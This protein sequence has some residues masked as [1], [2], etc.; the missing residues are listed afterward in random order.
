MNMLKTTQPDIG[1][2]T[3]RGKPL[4]GRSEGRAASFG[5]EDAELHR[6]ALD[7]VQLASNLAG[8]R[9]PTP[10]SGAI[11][12]LK[13]L[14]RGRWYNALMSGEMKFPYIADVAKS[15]ALNKSVQSVLRAIQLCQSSE[16]LTQILVPGLQRLKNALGLL[17]ANANRQIDQINELIR[18]YLMSRGAAKVTAKLPDIS[19]HYKFFRSSKLDRDYHEGNGW[20]GI[21]GKVKTHRR[22]AAQKKVAGGTGD[23]AGHLIGDRFGAPGG[24]ENLGPQNWKANRGGTFKEL[25][26][27]WDMRLKTGH[28]VFVRVIDIANKG[29]TRPFVR[30]VHWTEVAPDGRERHT[31]IDFANM[32]TPESRWAQAVENVAIEAPQLD[33]VV[34]VDFARR[35]RLN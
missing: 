10:L 20:L 19:K 23:D 27:H 12:A 15:G 33:N 29:S 34:Y 25:E 11:D 3:T 9:E 2:P 35:R 16:Q 8:F 21:P 30:R 4:G 17:P 22:H 26:D 6:V 18:N 24:E 5:H 7:L 31:S 32:H 14:A 1:R 13:L 28:A